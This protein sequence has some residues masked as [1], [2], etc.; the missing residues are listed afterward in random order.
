MDVKESPYTPTA[1]TSNVDE[2]RTHRPSKPF[3]SAGAVTLF[4]SFVAVVKW[5]V[6]LVLGTGDFYTLGMWIEEWTIALALGVVCAIANPKSSAVQ[7]LVFFFVAY[8][9]HLPVFIG[10]KFVFLVIGIGFVTCFVMYVGVLLGTV[11]RFGFDWATNSRHR[12]KM[13]KGQR[14]QAS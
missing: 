6:P 9:L 12:R 13:T 5:F 1:H 14:G 2:S 11:L 3:L 8:I 10:D 7:P 4:V